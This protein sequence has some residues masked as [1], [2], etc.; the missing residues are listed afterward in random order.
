MSLNI[1]YLPEYNYR[2][3]HHL[4][5]KAS[6][7]QIMQS[8][9]S[10]NTADDRFFTC[11]IK[12]R[13]LPNRLFNRTKRVKADLSLE[14]LKHENFS[15]DNFTLLERNNNQEV[16]YGLAGQ[17]WK[18]DYGQYTLDDNQSFLTFNQP[19]CVKLI[20]YF[21]LQESDEGSTRV[22]TETRVFC[23]DRNAFLKFRPYWYL[24]RPI[25]GLI[26]RRMLSQILKSAIKSK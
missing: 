11:A 17:L 6:P 14:N 22:T 1:K 26:R 18:I 21:S 23:L 15:L 12:L 25:S 10:Y 19:N 24:I 13:E 3:E 7:E 8:I 16:V 5:M 2:E 9:L 4:D 20:L